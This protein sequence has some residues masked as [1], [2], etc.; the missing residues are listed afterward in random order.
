MHGVAVD[1][2]LGCASTEGGP[3][4]EAAVVEGE[5]GREVRVGVVLLGVVDAVAVPVFLSV[6]D[7]VAVGVAVEGVGLGE[8]V[9]D[10]VVDAVLV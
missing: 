9:F 4:G 2:G 7:A 8:L 6:G 3:E 10:V 1:D 5:L